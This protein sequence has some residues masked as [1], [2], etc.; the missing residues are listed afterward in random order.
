M[1]VSMP[2]LPPRAMVQMKTTAGAALVAEIH[3]KAGMNENLQKAERLSCGRPPPNVAR[4]QSTAPANDSAGTR[5]DHANVSSV[6]AGTQ[7]H[8]DAQ[9]ASAKARKRSNGY[10]VPS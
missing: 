3:A 6:F 2:L 10:H 7:M 4:L 8:R 1:F 5:L 9:S